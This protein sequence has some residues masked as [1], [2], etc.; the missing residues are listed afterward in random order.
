VIVLFADEDT[1]ALRYTRE[2]SAAPSGY[3]VHVDNICTDPNLLTLY[4]SLDDPGGAR[5]TYV[6]PEGRPY[7][8]DLPALPAGHPLGTARSGETVVAI[9]DTGAFMDTRSCNEWWQ[10]R[11]GY[12]GPCPS[13]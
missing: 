6:P 8:Y 5:Y 3:T 13:P 9:V 1:V 11:P 7:G 4:N 12:T 2:D 10:I